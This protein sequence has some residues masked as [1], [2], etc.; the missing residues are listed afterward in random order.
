MRNF[1]LI[2]FVLCTT[3]L[4]SQTLT[5]NIL[6]NENQPVANATV[7]AIKNKA[8]VTTNSKG[9]FR[10][11]LSV[12]PDTLYITHV[13]YQQQSVIV[14]TAAIPISLYLQPLTVNLEEITVNTG[15]QKLKPNEVS[16]SVTQV[17]NKE[18]NQ[19]VGTNIL[20]RLDGITSGLTVNEGFGNGNAQN[21]TNI[22]IR[23]LSTINGPLDPLIVLDN[24]IYEGS[25]ANI[26]PNDIE[27]ITVLKDAAAA[28]IWGARAGNGVIVITTKRGRFNQKPKLE[29]NSTFIITQKPDLFSVPEMSIADYLQV[30]EFLFNKGY[31][32][33][34]ISQPHIPLTPAVELFLKRKNGLITA[35]DSAQ[36][37]NALK[38][39]DSKK[40]FE[41]YGYSQAATQQ[42]SLNLR[43]GSANLAWLIAAA[44]DK[45]SDHLSS[46]YDKLNVR[47]NNT[48]KPV[49]D[50]LIDVAVYYTASKSVTGKTN[51]GNVTRINGRY[52][53]YLRLADENGTA[54][55][56][57]QLYRS[58]YTDTAGAGKLLNWKY[59]PLEEQNHSKGTLHTNEIVANIG[60]GYKLF[61]ALQLDL[62]YQYQQQAGNNKALSTIESFNTRN[63]IN[64][65]SQLNRA[66]GVVNYIVPLGDILS[67]TNSKLQS[68]NIRAQA[69]Y[70]KTWNDHQFSLMAGAE[71]REVKANANSFTYFG[72]R[73]D[74]LSYTAV[75]LVNTYPTFVTGGTARISGDFSL[76]NTINRFLSLY[77]NLSYTYRQRYTLFSSARKD[78]SN[79]FGVNTNDKWKPLWSVGAG[80]ELSREKFYHVD[81][82]PLVK[83]KATL[84]YSGN[85]DLS[86][87]ALPVAYYSPDFTTRLPSA[88]ISTLNNPE[89]RWEQSRQINIGVVFASKGNIVTGS[90]DWYHKKGT[91]LYGDA[92]FDYTTWG[93]QN[94]ILR[95]VAAIAGHGLDLMITTKNI[96]KVFK[97]YTTLLYNYNTSKTTKYEELRA[98]NISSLMGGGKNISPVIGKP[99]YAIAAYKWGGLD[100]T[101][102]P[103]GYLNGQLSTNYNAIYAEAVANGLKN[104]N[105]FFVGS[106]AP[107]SFGSLINTIS[108][109]RLECSFNLSY[110][111]GHYFVK[112]SLS[113]SGIIT[114]GGGNKEYSVRW[115]KPGDETFT[116]VP[117]F[118][119]P[120]NGNRD[121]FYHQSE[122]NVLK[123]DHVRLRYINL[124]YTLLPKNKGQHFEQVQLYINVSNLGIIWRA[125]NKDIDP[126]YPAGLPTPKTLAFGIRANF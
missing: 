32:N 98:N 58:T 70:T 1:I 43:G 11:T 108:W 29:F 67:L 119:Y 38:N 84:G 86:K 96:D 33:N 61:N 44:Y 56:V 55:P 21:K 71:A 41:K 110:K 120:A 121:G 42:Y 9:A 103:Q 105:L 12:L 122:I 57:A 63:I 88:T 66:T 106:A 90:V 107:V 53:P 118:V 51:Y 109:K 10:I 123:A 114:G 72:Y 14:T 79:I 100:A 64:L 97:W 115:Q 125:N 89:L 24:F 3:A 92:P 7:T 19:Q 65:Y 60:I 94:T 69:T 54:L 82:I 93:Q 50:L 68:Q 52:V 101:G 22:T 6:N 74:P 13:S 34:N 39:I 49:K 81:L 95:N 87:S 75:D 117:A 102:N 5:G 2:C 30:E 76:A 25:I 16:G 62:K 36:Q 18:L 73:P 27:S 78:G 40:L 35:S 17:S 45:S 48:F 28:S 91:D 31:F 26:N 80:W 104:G 37:L 116:N 124:S 4:K 99:L 77:S 113:S 47:F 111:L 20:K 23:G 59:Y 15:Y 8:T 126:D 83:L 85:V 112:P 46:T